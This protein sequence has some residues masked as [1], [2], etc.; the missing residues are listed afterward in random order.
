MDLSVTFIDKSTTFADKNE[1]KVYENGRS[2]NGC[3]HVKF[4]VVLVFVNLVWL[5]FRSVQLQ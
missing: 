1:V 4:S 3:C 5:Q 2:V